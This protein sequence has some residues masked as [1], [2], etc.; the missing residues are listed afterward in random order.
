[1]FG[2][3]P[4]W[5]PLQDQ[6]NLTL[7]IRINN[8]QY[9]SS[10]LFVLSCHC[11]FHFDSFISLNIYMYFRLFFIFDCEQHFTWTSITGSWSLFNSWFI[12][13]ES[14]SNC[15]FAPIFKK[16]LLVWLF[17][18][19]AILKCCNMH[20]LKK[21]FPITVTCIK[22]IVRIKSKRK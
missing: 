18:I 3:L 6:A 22:N 14:V 13:I 8:I 15:Y 16:D 4:D 17:Y 7:T 2:V 1:M 20:S 5:A 19:V 11:R 10:L 21:M 9:S 12:L